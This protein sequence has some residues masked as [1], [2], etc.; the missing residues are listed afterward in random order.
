VDNIKLKAMIAL[1]LSAAIVA[2][3][4]TDKIRQVGWEDLRIK[5]EFEDPF[6]A[7]TPDQ[8]YDLGTYARV[9]AMQVS[10]TGRVTEAMLM[11]AKEAEQA[12]RE[13]DVD[14]EGLLAQREKIK[15]LREK[16]AHAM[17][18]TLDG[19]HIRIPGYALPLEYDGRKVT[20]FLLVPW[21][22]ACIHTPPPPPNQIVFVALD[23]GVV[24]GDR[25]QP[26]WV[27][28]RI[29]VGAVSKDLF[30]VDGSAQIH[31][32]Y[33]ISDGSVEKYRE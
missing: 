1:L 23:E 4:A 10:R 28:G 29:S 16:R 25:F 20:E 22:G 11:E 5:V 8:L 3:A 7:L 30:L 27:T 32:G 15:A 17:D 21:V 2:P 9:A 18:Q 19:L 31:I 12:L 33:A 26:V 13:A 24:T 14:I 6:A